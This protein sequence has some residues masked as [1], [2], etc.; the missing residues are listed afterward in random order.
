MSNVIEFVPCPSEMEPDI[1]CCDCECVT[2][3]LHASEAI[4]CARCRT[5]QAKHE[6]LNLCG[7][8]SANQAGFVKYN[9]AKKDGIAKSYSAACAG[10]ACS[11]S[12][13]LASEMR[14]NA[15]A[16]SA[17]ISTSGRAGS[18]SMRACWASMM[19]LSSRKVA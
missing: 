12:I 14:A 19:V 10:R 9:V 13:N 16:R 4:E 17:W 8:R 15:K 6:A 3:Y 2:F 7:W 5:V 18:R 11:A 1:W